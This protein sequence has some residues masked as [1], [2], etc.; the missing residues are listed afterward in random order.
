MYQAD[1]LTFV[2]FDDKNGSKMGPGELSCRTTEPFAWDA[3]IIG[4]GIDRHVCAMFI[5]VSLRVLN[6]RNDVMCELIQKRISGEFFDSHLPTRWQLGPYQIAKGSYVQ[7]DLLNQ[8]GVTVRVY[9][10]LYVN[11]FP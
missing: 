5:I 11:R 10:Q 8:S 3:E 6:V 7:L 9:P 2:G 1:F 4:L